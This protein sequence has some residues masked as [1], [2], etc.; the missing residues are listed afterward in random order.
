MKIEKIYYEENEDICQIMKIFF[1]E[2]KLEN[3]YV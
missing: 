1:Q 3:I 2:S